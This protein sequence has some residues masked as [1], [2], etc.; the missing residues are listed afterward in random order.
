LHVILSI[1]YTKDMSDLSVL[2]DPT[3]CIILATSP[4][5]LGHLRVTDALYHG[6]PKTASPI[7]LGAQAPIESTLYRF[8]SL[9]PLTRKIMEMVEMPPFDKPAAFIGRNFFRSQTKDIYLQLKTILNERLVVPK[10]V[11]LVSSH[12]ILSHQMGHI[13]KKLALEMGVKIILVQQVTDDS[14]QAIWYV[15]DADLI[16]V[17]SEYTKRNLLDYARKAHLPLV[18]IA[19]TAYP[20]S[21]LLGEPISEHELSARARQLNPHAKED[22]HIT[23][24]VSGAAVG[25][26]F[27]SDYIQQ[28]HQYSSRFVFHVVSRDAP[29]TRSFIQKVVNLP[30]VKLSISNHDR[31]TVDNYEKV[32]IEE[33]I[34]LEI[35]KPSEQAFKALL[36]PKQKG[37]VIILFSTP[38]GG[39]EYDNLHFLRNHS[40][41]PNLHDHKILWEQAEKNETIN[42]GLLIKAHHWRALRLPAE[43]EKAC[44]FTTWCMRE[45]LFSKMLDYTRVEKGDEVQANGVEQFWKHVVRLIEKGKVDQ[46]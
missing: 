25:T 28:M 24:P 33:T 18:P 9:N 4:T 10:T 3:V 11:L 12:N 46:E 22:I 13:K 44:R 7:L 26:S 45:G 34:A 36:T 8:V 17:P 30:Y 20:V 1:D 23:V 15:Y 27:I 38:V 16:F 14:P 41:M 43:T 5:G 6:L 32:F 29:F 21:P 31:T 19:V 42:P 35:T 2:S 40:L 39:Q 37:G